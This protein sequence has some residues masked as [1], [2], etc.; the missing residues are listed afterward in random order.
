M[1]Y[2]NANRSDEDNND[3]NKTTLFRGDINCLHRK[4]K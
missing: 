3:K 1:T 2:K 4:P